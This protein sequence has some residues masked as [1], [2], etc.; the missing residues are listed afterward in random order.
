VYYIAR[1]PAPEQVAPLL[2]VPA[3]RY[4]RILLPLLARALALGRPDLIGWSLAIIGVLSQVLGTLAV[5]A[6]IHHWG[7]S[8]RYA[9]VY[10]LWVGFSL[11][12]RLD[13]PEPLAYGLVAGAVLAYEG[14]RRRLAWLLYG[15]AIFAKEV[16]VLFVIAQL[17]WEIRQKRWPA[18]GELFAVALVPYGL[19]QLWLAQTFGAPGIGS[20]GANA[21][22]FEVLP[23]GG[24][25]QVARVD[26]LVFGVFILVF[27][28]S[29]LLPALWGLKRTLQ[30]VLDGRDRLVTYLL[31]VNAAVIPF[32]PFSTFRE[33][34]GLLRFGCGLVLAFLAYAAHHRL[35]RPLN[36][37]LFLLA[38]NVFLIE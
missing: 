2:D 12:V 14:D 9:L 34:G 25:L 32:L 23:F 19:F 5:A 21:T 8:V 29:I 11:A 16:T 3:Y 38:L 7:A 35:R 22:G 33:P 6:L 27:G 15:L 1:E 18:A 31:G 17:A 13:L 20:G 30:E 26:L 36:Y 24:L 37:A 4:Q 28:P 10:G